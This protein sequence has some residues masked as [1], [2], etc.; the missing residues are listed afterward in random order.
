M[1]LVK[2]VCPSC[3]LVTK[4][5]PAAKEVFHACPEKRLRGRPQAVTFKAVSA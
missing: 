1:S 4:V 3:G 2:H 5:H